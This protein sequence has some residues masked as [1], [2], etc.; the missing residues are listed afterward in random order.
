MKRFDHSTYLSPFTWRYGSYKLGLLFSVKYS[1][2]K[3]RSMTERNKT[4]LSLTELTAVTPLD[5]R[6]RNRTVELAPYVSESNLIRTRVEI[7]AKYLLALSGVG[8]IRR[9]TPGERERLNSFGQ[10]LTT[11]AVQRVK[12]VEDK[13]RHD[14]KAMETIFRDMVQGTSLE[15]LTK[16]I[17]FGLTSED[18][19]NL[20][21]RLMLQRA[22]N[23]VMI[24]LLDSFID[25]LVERADTTKALPMLARTHGQPALPTTLGKELVVFASR[26]NRETR[27]LEERPLRGK[28]TGAVGNLNALRLAYPKVD[29]VDFSRK[30]VQ[31]FGF[32]PNL[33]T[34]QTDP[35]EDMIAYFQN[36]QRVN[37]VILDFDQDMWRY[38]SDDWFVQEVREGE[39]GSSTMAQK[40]NPIDFENSEGNLGLANALFEHLSR[41]LAISRLQRD[42]SDSTVVRN[43]G[44]A[45]AYCL[46]GYS[47][48]IEGL[49]RVKP[50]E[51]MIAEVLNKDWS[52]L[53]EAVQTVLRRDGVDN[54]YDLVS[55]RTRGRHI[56]EDQWPAFI[57][58][59]PVDDKQKAGLK[60][61]SP[62]TYIG[63]A[64]EL[65]D[66]AIGE[67]RSS[68]KR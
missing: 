10:T 34:T 20:A 61:L 5:G 11:E 49:S 3:A 60:K 40:V 6:Y 29:W 27:E 18:I 24:P 26:L 21:Y 65:T 66:R 58:E 42:L 43:I 8:I 32:E 46:V 63:D 9:L 13:T 62:Q 64:V 56:G 17:H 7:E 50:N 37:G 28:L 33:A 67:I 45:L 19:N 55:E 30:F 15:D 53:T 22:T 47:S 38:I 2:Y 52:I 25:N 14:V 4:K 59:L 12:Q 54:A 35:Y 16:M 48:V 68:R 36:Y 41:K 23:E 51:R 57:D 1:T 39:R 44:T 31:S